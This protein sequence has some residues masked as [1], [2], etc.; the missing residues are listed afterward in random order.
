MANPRFR[1]A[2]YRR[3]FGE[4]APL[5]SGRGTPSPLTLVLIFF[6]AFV[7][8]AMAGNHVSSKTIFWTAI[9]MVVGLTWF[10]TWHKR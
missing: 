9:G 2:A 10:D 3:R 5:R 1:R 6:G 7:L 4:A 8:V